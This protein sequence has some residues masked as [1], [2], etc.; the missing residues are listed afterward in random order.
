MG[1][2]LFY[3][4]FHLY[5][6]RPGI[7]EKGKSSWHEEAGGES[8]GR[9]N[10]SMKRSIRDGV[11]SWWSKQ[12]ELPLITEFII[13]II[14]SPSLTLLPSVLLLLLLLIIRNESF[15]GRYE[16]L[17]LSHPSLTHKSTQSARN[18]QAWYEPFSFFFPNKSFID[19]G[20]REGKGWVGIGKGR[21]KWQ[22]MTRSGPEWVSEWRFE[23]PIHLALFSRLCR[24]HPVVSS[25]LP[26]R[27]TVLEVLLPHHSPFFAFS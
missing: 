10:E 16:G 7:E 9:E 14:T 2:V 27:V 15:L 21:K 6:L 5:F 17:L 1:C 23:E 22:K 8:R 11:I 20:G 13:I 19:G 4:F 25:S 12:S 26:L 3:L 24:E 18:F